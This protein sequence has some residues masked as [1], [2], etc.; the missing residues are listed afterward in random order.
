MTV[1]TSIASG[2]SIDPT[3]GNVVYT[4]PAATPAKP[5]VAATP[6]ATTKPAATTTVADNSAFGGPNAT[7]AAAANAA[8]AIPPATSPFGSSAIPI[9]AQGAKQAVVNGANVLNTPTQTT[10][11]QSFNYNGNSFDYSKLPSGMSTTPPANQAST[12]IS[13]PFG[14]VYIAQGPTLAV[15][16]GNGTT[17]PAGGATSLPT[18]Y[19]QT[20]GPNGSTVITNANGQTVMTIP[21]GGDTSTIASAVQNL[22]SIQGQ[23]GTGYNATVDPTGN[24]A[25]TAPDGTALPGLGKEAAADPQSVSSAIGAYDSYQSTSAAA[26]ATMNANIATLQSQY[27]EQ[28]QQLD[29]EEDAAVGEE[30]A[31]LGAGAL[32]SQSSVVANVKGRYDQLKADL[33]S[34][35]NAAKMTAQ[36]NSQSAISS[37]FAN[38]NQAITGINSNAQQTLI[39]VQNTAQTTF[40]NNAKNFDVSTAQFAD[41]TNLQSLTVGA[42]GTT[43]NSTVDAL[44]AEGVK[45]G[46]TPQGAL[47]L[48]QAG[49]ATQNKNNQAQFLGLLQQASYAN[50]WA[51]MTPDQLKSDP[52]YNAY[53]GMAQSYI[54]SLANN[55]SA[56]QA[57][58]SGGTIQQQKLGI[59][60]TGSPTGATPETLVAA[61]PPDPTIGDQVG[62][63]VA[64]GTKYTPNAI[65]QDAIEYAMTGKVPTMGNGTA[66]QVQAA[67]AAVNNTAAAIVTASGQNFPQLQALYKANQSAATQSVQRLARI[68][69]V[70]NSTV[71]NFPRLETLAD[72]VKAAGVTL[73]EADLQAGSAVVQQKTGSADAAAY[74]ELINTVRSD[75]SAMQASIAGSRGGQFFSE[76]AAQAIPLGLT[77][78]QYKAIAKTISVSAT[79]ATNATNDEVNDL[80]SISGGSGT[81]GA[82]D[83]TDTTD[84]TTGGSTGSSDVSSADAWPGF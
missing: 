54:P 45:S 26:T 49:V 28:S 7:Q 9:V 81:V 43:G 69:I 50:G 73:T 30:L 65:Y 5:V 23:L 1:N 55:P 56:A 84:D 8:L 62:A 15:N 52:L 13:T 67:R 37:A 47:G 83:T 27:D 40:L 58:V 22:S 41:G 44:I 60:T 20:T 66:A 57:L 6:P 72:S 74:V 42:D 16:N 33:L 59:S 51:T 21:Q 29:Q 4:A 3:S 14:P 17:T 34:Q 71:N 18:G 68:S 32:G 63:G 48:V 38:M 2:I 61:A 12:T 75:Y 46:M 31:G 79:N 11:P 76:S 77:S 78:D 70:E 64:A 80:I 25:V 10:T 24:I 35:F 82:T 19:Q 39:G 53:V 36:S